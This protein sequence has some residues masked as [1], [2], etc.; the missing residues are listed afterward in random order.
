MIN[1]AIVEDDGEEADRLYSFLEQYRVEHQR[2]LQI[3]RFST[4]SSFETSFSSQ[5]ELIFLDIEL[6]DGNGMNLARRIR[7]KDTGVV[8]LFITHLAQYAIDGYTVSA[9]DYILKPIEYPSLALKLNRAM[10]RIRNNRQEYLTL[11]SG[12]STV[13]VST[14]EL[15][16]IEIYKH[17]IRYH[18]T[19]T[20][21]ESYGILSKVEESLPKKGFFRCSNS[22]IINLRFIDRFDSAN[23]YIQDVC[24]PV[25]RA[26]KKELITE[27]HRF[28]GDLD[29]Q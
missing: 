21:L 8:L 4:V 3:H 2:E 29:E 9:L 18:L 22:F 1:I 19:E 12:N 14:S 7:E 13:R 26:K 5:Y 17:H 24:I 20:T 16:Y 10:I 6:P 28:Y 11:R 25:S 23:V 15:K 27:Y